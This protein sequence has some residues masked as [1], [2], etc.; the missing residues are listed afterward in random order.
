MRPKKSAN[1]RATPPTRRRSMCSEAESCHCIPACRPWGAT[2]SPGSN[3]GLICGLRQ[4]GDRFRHNSRG[5]DFGK[6]ARAGLAGDVQHIGRH[7]T[8]AELGKRIC[9]GVIV[10]G[11]VSFEQGDVR[12][13]EGFHHFRVGKRDPLVYLATEAPTGGE[14][15]ENRATL[16]LI[17]GNSLW[18]PRRPWVF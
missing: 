12:I 13:G 6:K 2:I 3:S 5:E 14:I 8:A 15:N 4:A 1:T 16:R 18:C 17:L 9:D 7:A 11:P 10:L